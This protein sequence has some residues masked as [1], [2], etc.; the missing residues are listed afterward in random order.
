VVLAA[1]DEDVD[2]AM[3]VFV[4]R[5]TPRQRKACVFPSG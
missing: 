2:G 1:D 5:G 4:T 3:T